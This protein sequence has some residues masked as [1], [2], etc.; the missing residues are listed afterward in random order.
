MG[1][2]EIRSVLWW[3]VVVG[4]D[5]AARRWHRRRRR[6][7]PA[8]QWRALPPAARAPPAAPYT[9]LASR[10]VS[11]W[12]TA[13]LRI[14]LCRCTRCNRIRAARASPSLAAASFNRLLHFGATLRRVCELL[15]SWETFSKVNQWEGWVQARSERRQCQ[16]LWRPPPRTAGRALRGRL[17]VAREAATRCFYQWFIT[18]AWYNL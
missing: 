13:W 8:G 2:V 14:L 12:L 17:Q 18:Y 1:V 10:F 7:A 11:F 6:R 9:Q 4:D 5:G 3:L 15:Q 16:V